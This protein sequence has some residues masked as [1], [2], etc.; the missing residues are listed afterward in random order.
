MDIIS[1]NIKSYHIIVDIISHKC[2]SGYNI[3]ALWLLLAPLSVVAP[4]ACFAGGGT[5]GAAAQAVGPG[6][7]GTL[8]APRLVDLRK[9]AKKEWQ[10]DTLWVVVSWLFMFFRA[11]FHVSLWFV[12][13][14]ELMWHDLLI[15]GAKRGYLVPKIVSM[16]LIVDSFIQWTSRCS[17][18]S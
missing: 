11:F 7:V 16:W 12:N 15:L 3:I 17:M 14:C 2:N 6:A 1:T 4:G 5:S 10:N 13:W 9:D 18:F 8:G